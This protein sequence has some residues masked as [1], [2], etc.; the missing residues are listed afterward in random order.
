VTREPKY[1]RLSNSAFKHAAEEESAQPNDRADPRR[2]QTKKQCGS[3]LLR[4]DFGVGMTPDGGHVRCY[5][6][7]S[8]PAL[9]LSDK[10]FIAA[11]DDWLKLV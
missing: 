8:F 5:D 10:I 9:T 2:A 11:A 6:D 3:S 4:A 7:R 1:K